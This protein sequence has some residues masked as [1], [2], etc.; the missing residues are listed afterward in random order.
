[1]FFFSLDFLFIFSIWVS[2][3]WSKFTEVNLQELYLFF[4]CLKKQE[5][6]LNLFYKQVFFYFYWAMTIMAFDDDKEELLSIR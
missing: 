5:F 6:N 2:L 4:L 1:M 3:K